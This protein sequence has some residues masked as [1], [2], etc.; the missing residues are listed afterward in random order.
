MKTEIMSPKLSEP[1][2]HSD[3]VPVQQLRLP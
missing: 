2:C 3:V 1:F